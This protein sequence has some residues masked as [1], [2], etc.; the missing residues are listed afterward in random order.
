MV[1][2][3]IQGAKISIIKEVAGSIISTD[4]S[5]VIANLVLDLALSYTKAR[6]GSVLLLDEKGELVIK[7]AKGIDYELISALRIK[8]GENIC[9][10]V[11][12]EKIPLLVED[13]K[14]DKRI[15][16]NV[17]GNYETGSFICCPV[18]MRNRLFGVINIADKT[19]GSFFSEDEFDLVNILAGQTAISL[20]HALLMFEL[21][22]RTLELNET[23]KM[24]IDSDKFK[25]EFVTRMSHELRTPLNSITGA[26]YYLKEKTCSEVEQ[27]EFIDIISDES[28]KLIDLLDRLLDF[29]YIEKE[30]I[31]LKKKVL[32]LSDVIQEAVT[33]NMI[34]V[35]LAN[36]KIS[37]NVTSPDRSI[38]IIGEK[39]L[40]IQLVI[41]IIDGITKYSAAGDSIDV[42]VT[43]TTTSVEI[44]FFIKG[45]TFPENELPS[46]FNERYFWTGTDFDKNK[47]KLYLAKKITELHNGSI[48]IFNTDKGIT[49]QLL[50]PRSKKEYQDAGID[51]MT[52]LLVSFTAGLMDLNRCSLMLFD[53]LTGKLKIRNA[54]GLDNNIIKKTRLMSGNKIAG[55]AAIENRPFLIEDIE[56]DPRTRKKSGAQYN[57]KSLLCVPVTV[58]SKVV[59]VLNLNNKTNGL[60]FNKKD[61]YLAQA[62]T[63]R[64]SHVIEKVQKGDLKDKEFKDMS[65][66]IEALSSAERHYKK[67]NGK[68]ADL[69]LGIARHMK[70]SEDEIKLSLYAS[71]LYD[72]GLTQLDQSI[73]MKT[74]KLSEIEKRIIKTH[75]FPGV[76]LINH[77]EP[78]TTVRKG[79]LHHHERY[80]GSGYPDGLHGDNIPFISRV[81]AVAD[82]YTALIADRPYRKEVSSKEAI[83]Q[84]IA[85][86]GR[87]FDPEVIDA[88]I[89]TIRSGN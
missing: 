8:I 26:V 66:G 80:D 42:K 57:T 36:N 88:F 60:P 34:E 77:I 67:K 59:G 61:L 21:R 18:L 35:A 33:S 4:N 40:L 32:N 14:S 49:L 11:A 29:S 3:D 85:G 50:L 46:I 23:N 72:L 31:I 89:K 37:V 43:D 19:D 13:I 54:L 52:D 76:G 38:S 73:L 58:N 78:D 48:S 82:T 55:R 56:K 5:D 87:Q 70:R 22:S 25:T 81:I 17:S 86:A 30:E 65:K 15:E 75:P 28:R 41:N 69:V 68:L 39:S 24:L 83:E 2:E 6:R 12:E 16:K 79:I 20:D 84:V 10:K 27:T 71:A 63:E 53:E 44:E 74:E 9:G 7:A 45:R 64:I 47:M 51:E 1:Q 62:V